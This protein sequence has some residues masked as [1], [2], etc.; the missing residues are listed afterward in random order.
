LLW[1]Q[2]TESRSASPRN[3]LTAPEIERAVL[4]AL[5]LADITPL[6]GREHYSADALAL[7]LDVADNYP[8]PAIAA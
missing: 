7:V 6:R 4:A 8:I 2:S 1:R 5:R 3:H